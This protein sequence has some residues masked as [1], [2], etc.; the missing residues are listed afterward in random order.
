MSLETIKSNVRSLHASYGFEK[1]IKELFE[2]LVKEVQEQE[3]ELEEL[4][5]ELDTLKAAR[6]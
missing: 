5:K 1:R 3:E 6:A 4:H 2:Q